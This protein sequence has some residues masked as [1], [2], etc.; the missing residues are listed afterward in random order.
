MSTVTQF[1]EGQLARRLSTISGVSEVRVYGSQKY[2]VRL[3]MDPNAMAALGIGIDEVATAVSAAN[4]NKGTG[5][6]S[7]PT[8][9]A[10]IHTSGQLFSAADYAT[11]VVAYRNG[12]PVRFNE[13]GKV[14]DSVEDTKKGSWVGDSKSVT[15]AIMRQPGA[16]T[17]DVIDSIRE[18]LPSYEKQLPPSTSLQIFYDRS[19]S[20]RASIHDV[21][22]TLILAAVLVVIVIFVFLRNLSAT[23]IPSLALPISI[24]GTFAGMSALGFGLDNLSLMALTLSVGFVVDDAIVMLENIVRHHEAGETPY[25]ASVKGAREITFT[26]LSMTA[27][28]AAV[29]IPVLFMGGMIGRLLNAFS[30]TIIMAIIVSGIVSLTLTPMMCSRLIRARKSKHGALYAS[31]ERGFDALQ[32]GYAKTLHWSIA[33][34][35]VIYVLF[36]MSIIGTGVLFHFIPKSFLPSGDSGRLVAFTQ[37]PSNISYDE[38]VRNQ[39]LAAS[40]ISKDK[41]VASIM[42]SVGAG[43]SRD[44]VSSGMMIIGL[45][46][47]A[48]RKDSANEIVKRLR[49]TTNGIP[50][51]KVFLSNPPMIRIGGR[52]SK[53]EYQYT[54]Q[55]T[56]LETLYASANQLTEAL[57]KEDGFLDVTNNMDIS[58]PAVAI[59][60]NREQTAKV[61]VTVLQIENALA[62][63]FSTREV[64]TI[65]AADDQYSVIL[66]LLPKYQTDASALDLLYVRSQNGGL[67]PLSTLITVK[68]DVIAQTVNH[69]GQLPAVTVSFNLDDIALSEAIDRIHHVEATIH[70]PDTI[71]SEFSGA[72]KTFEE[73]TKGLGL[74]L[75]LAIVVVY[76]VLGILYESFIHPLTILSGLPSAA[77]GALITLE[78]FDLPLS[79][80]AFVGIIML[81]GI[82]KKNAIMMID[83]ALV[84]ER[85]HGATASEAI[86]E[87]AIIRFRPIMMTTM[88]ALMGT[89]PI[90]LALG[91]GGESR[92]PLGLAVVGGLILSQ[93]LTLYITPVLYIFFDRV[94]HSLQKTPRKIPNPNIDG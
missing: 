63:A 8:R 44:S 67:V 78:L 4:V 53:S 86:I 43:G 21:Q 94:G 59:A 26:I 22:F 34:K 71:I 74:L 19:Q 16:N 1:A 55:D 49:K 66:E 32:N 2:A 51:L 33:H 61:G 25:N 31:C 60:I 80:Y 83:F 58:A 7:G 90:A 17:I 39:T 84:Q 37:G 23:L 57:S 11:Q 81:V 28:L 82:V 30:L 52:L 47:Y 40:I 56:N 9:R 62:S 75:L 41:S 45:T 88:A 92:Q 72:A 65:F 10:M 27:S 35:S 36:L 15:L 6:F 64:S 68:H 42:S 29:F 3:Q 91:A 85:K 76:I 18:I 20:I 13:I 69:Q 54:L 70:M 79:I 48:T 87:A 73:S 46:D 5:E 89:L 12:A 77:V 24:I 38:M 93:A 14:I 50:G